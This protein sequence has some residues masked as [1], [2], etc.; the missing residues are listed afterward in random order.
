MIKL[1]NPINLIDLMVEGKDSSYVKKRSKILT[2][3]FF[4]I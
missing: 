3:F 2:L 4:S 1:I